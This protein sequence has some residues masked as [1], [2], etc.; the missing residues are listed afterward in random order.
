MMKRGAGVTL[1]ILMGLLSGAAACSSSGSVQCPPMVCD[2]GYAPSP[3][4]C[5]C[6]PIK[7]SSNADCAGA[8]LAATCID[9]S[10]FVPD[11]V[12]DAGKPDAPAEA[13]DAT[14]T[15]APSDAA[16]AC[17]N[18]GDVGNSLGVGK[19]CTKARDCVGLAALLCAT[20]G[21]PD[22]HFCTKSCSPQHD[23]G[24]ECGEG[25]TCTCDPRGCGCTLNGCTP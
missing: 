2:P 1:A 6:E 21:N 14:P 24:T 17:G 3:N 11:A 19:Y 9:G 13:A 7:C 4:S 15:D 25:A 8:S 23:S 22:N 10:C 16:S 20:A 5:A 12:Y 18:P